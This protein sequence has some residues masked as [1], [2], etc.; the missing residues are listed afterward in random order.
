MADEVVDPFAAAQ[1]NAE[2]IEER[3]LT[4]VRKQGRD[5]AILRGR[6]LGEQT[7]AQKGETGDD[8]DQRI[9]RAMAY[10]AWEFDGKPEGGAHLV[11]FGVR[12]HEVQDSLVRRNGR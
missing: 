5:A 10:A 12:R 3:K 4:A 11:E 7:A 9:A 8:R 6:L 2:V 1:E